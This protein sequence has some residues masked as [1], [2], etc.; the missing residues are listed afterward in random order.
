MEERLRSLGLGRESPGIRNEENFVQGKS[1]NMEC[2]K[3]CIGKFLVIRKILYKEVPCDI[4]K[5][6]MQKFLNRDNLDMK[7]KTWSG[8]ITLLLEQK[9]ESCD[10]MSEGSRKTSEQK[11]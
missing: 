8:N 7:G 10:Y 5:S 6:C 11:S 1:W 2:G 4:G 9:N 3:S